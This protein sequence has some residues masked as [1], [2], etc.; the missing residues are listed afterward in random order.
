MNKLV[1]P[2]AKRLRLLNAN[3]NLTQH[4]KITHQTSIA[5]ILAFLYDSIA[6][7]ASV[8]SPRRFLLS[9][10]LKIRNFIRN[11]IHIVLSISFAHI[12]IVVS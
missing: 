1:W 10:A 8:E 9:T 11:E 12:K 6:H 7:L 4:R 3:Y 2:L 5:F